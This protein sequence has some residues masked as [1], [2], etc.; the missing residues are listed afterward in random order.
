MKASL[1]SSQAL[2]PPKAYI[3]LLEVFG[4]VLIAVLFDNIAVLVAQIMAR[5]WRK[6][7]SLRVHD[8]CFVIISNVA[9][10]AVALHAQLLRDELSS[11]GY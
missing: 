4:L 6:E 7:I 3:G 1:I 2:D 11:Q 9:N 5:D 10:L 8:V